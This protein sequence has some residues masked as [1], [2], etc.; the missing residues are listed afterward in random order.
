MVYKYVTNIIL[1]VYGYERGLSNEALAAPKIL[2]VQVICLSR[3][4]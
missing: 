2:P 4:R 3:L 1:I